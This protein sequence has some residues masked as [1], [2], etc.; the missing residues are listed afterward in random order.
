[1]QMI[2]DALLLMAPLVIFYAIW[3]ITK[4]IEKDENNE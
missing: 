3:R 1:M 2:T 4:S